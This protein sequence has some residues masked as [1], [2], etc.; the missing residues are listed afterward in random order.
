MSFRHLLRWGLPAGLLCLIAVP[1]LKRSFAPSPPSTPS[2]PSA[3]RATVESR[4]AEF[5][6]V[7]AERLRADFAAAGV[8]YPPA[9]LVFAAFKE[10][11]R[12]ELHAARD[13][14]E[15][16]R[17][18]RA[19]PV[20]GASGRLGPKLREGDRQVPEGLYRLEYLN[21]NSR[22]HLSMK[23]D[24]PNAF[25]RE[26]AWEEGRDQPGSDIMIHGKAVSIGCLAMGDEAAEDLFVLAALTGIGNVDVIV[27]PVD[28]RTRAL[29]AQMP[30]TPEWTPAL[31]ARLREALRALPLPR[32]QGLE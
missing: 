10:E 9:R 23:L 31:Y 20:Q 25:D 6:P 1:I 12:L 13:A 4:V 8:P 17:F 21:P 15:P 29:P 30:P 16:L 32:K 28:F 27:S 18:I 19:Y 24:Y 2:T 11:R 26:R 3:D 7:V 14:G 22:Y 5:G